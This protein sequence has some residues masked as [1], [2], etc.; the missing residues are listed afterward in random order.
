M[1]DNTWRYRVGAAES[2]PISAEELC[3]LFSTGAVSINVSVWC[4]P[5]KRWVSA[6]TIPAFR[7]A[8]AAA[9]SAAHLPPPL[10]RPLPDGAFHRKAARVAWTAPIIAIVFS[11]LAGGGLRAAEQ[12]GA[13][14]PK[15]QIV[16][17][18]FSATCILVGFFA[19]VIALLGA[20]SNV[21]RKILLPAMVGVALNGFIILAGVCTL[22]LAG[23]VVAGQ[24]DIEREGRE[25]V[26][27][28]PGWVG[29]GRLPMGGMIAVN[30]LD[31]D[32]P[33]ARRLLG[34]M[35]TRCSVI[36]IAV[37]GKRSSVFFYDPA[38]LV[39]L[40]KYGPINALPVDAVAGSASA[41]IATPLRRL[42]GLQAIT[43]DANV[44]E[45][46]CFVPAG[47]NW[48]DVKA[49]SL[50]LDGKRITLTGRL[51]SATEKQARYEE[52]SRT[53]TTLH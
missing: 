50:D 19:G 7:E 45:A 11:F 33:T 24:T 21:R 46:V 42:G 48:S 27:K 1:S 8:A 22:T 14:N 34:P 4:A 35:H 16:V 12:T 23:R 13:S 9:P 29:A 32:S 28:Y 20:P 53:G 40:T 26:L 25:S 5:I 17:G 30:T 18:L 3:R 31:D 10:L 6:A 15:G 52:A 39:L 41:D 2:E 43:A 36:S 44:Q 47:V 38:S 51:C 49:I 37:A